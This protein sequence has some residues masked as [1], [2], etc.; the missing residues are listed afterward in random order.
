MSPRRSSTTVRR[1]H[2][3]F[4][5]L[6]FFPLFYSHPVVTRWNKDPFALGSYAVPSFPFMREFVP[7][8]ASDIEKKLFFAGE[9]RFL[10][11]GFLL[12]FE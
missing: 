8:L 6:Y 3:E 5:H 2:Q 1:P 11:I 10:V 7:V 4:C 12:R 9:V